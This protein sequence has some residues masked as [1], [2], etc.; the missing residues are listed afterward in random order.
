MN[1]LIYLSS[2][3]EIAKQALNQKPENIDVVYWLIQWGNIHF[4]ANAHTGKFSYDFDPWMYIASYPQTRDFFW[5]FENNTLN[6]NSACIAWIT[7]GIPNNLDPKYFCSM[8]HCFSNIMSP[9]QWM[10]TNINYPI[11]QVSKGYNKHNIEIAN[12]WYINLTHRI[13]R[14]ENIIKQLNMTNCPFFERFDAVN[15]RMYPTASALSLMNGGSALHPKFQSID[16]IIEDNLRVR[17]KTACT[18]SHYHLWYR[19]SK[20]EPNT[21][22]IIFEDDFIVNYSWDKFMKLF[23]L[24]LNNH[25]NCDMLVFSNRHGI[26]RAN[27]NSKA[28]FGTDG[29]ALKSDAAKRL[30]DK[31]QPGHELYHSMYSLDNHYDF[32]C[33]E[34]LLSIHCLNLPWITNNGDNNSDIE[35]SS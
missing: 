26:S 5:D 24:N 32:L 8:Q 21:W 23:K 6:V 16:W 3:P 18:M 35:I 4:L 12:I 30:L 2:N 25:T 14:N 17:A 22:V 13:D 10:L 15:A 31:C 7:V 20:Y 34:K 27:T 29:Y 33:S 11:E 1:P 28:A 19:A 9:A